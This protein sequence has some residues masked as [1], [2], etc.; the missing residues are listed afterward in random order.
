[1]RVKLW[2][3]DRGV[4]VVVPRRSGLW[5]AR[6]IRLERFMLPP[7]VAENF[8]PSDGTMIVPI[9]KMVSRSGFPFG[10]DGWH[11]YVA[12]LRQ[13]INDPSLGYRDTT[14]YAF[15]RRFQPETVHDLLLDGTDVPRATLA[16]WPAVDP[17][18]DLWAVTEN[19]AR[20]SRREVAYRQV[21]P[22][23]QY[24]GPTPEEYGARHLER[25]LAV[26]DSLM[27]SGHQPPYEAS[28]L[29]TGYF[30]TRAGD[31]RFVVGHGNHRVPAM[32][33]FGLTTLRVTLRRT[34]L[35]VVAEDRLDRWTTRRGGLLEP[36][37][38]TAVFNRFFRNDS[39]ARAAR[40]GLV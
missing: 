4:E 8:D 12:A 17:L 26:Y 25:C 2:L 31:Y 30:L 20:A 36:H 37:E 32:S 34:H 24:R 21:L 13:Q 3:R 40:L 38:V 7:E 23:S 6:H 14:L 10:R 35:A 29:V 1:M 11:P 16:T 5:G 18:I 27:E 39:T 9:N 19:E 28:R 22:H 15:Y 33:V